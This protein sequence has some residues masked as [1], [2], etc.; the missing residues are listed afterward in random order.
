MLEIR[1]INPEEFPLVRRMN[2]VVYNGRHDFSREEAPDPLAYPHRW[3]WAAFE[4]GKMVSSLAEIPYLMR[5]DGHDARMSGIGGVG[6]LPEAR[7][8][9]N[10]RR[11]FEKL[12]GGA[13]EEGVV[14]SSLTPFSHAFYRKFGYELACSRNEV[15]ISTREFLELPMRGKFTQVFPGD[16]TADLQKIHGAYIAGLN[17]GIR[18]DFWPENRAWRMFTRDDPYTTGI[19]LYLWRDEAG[20]PGGYIQYQ[21]ITEN[22]EHLMSV[23]ELAFTCRD[24]LYGVLSL[25]SGLS[26]QFKTFLWH[27]PTFL[28]PTD[29]GPP[30]WD[31]SQRIIPRDMT[32]IINVKA[33]LELMRKP[34]GEGS[35]VLEA[36]D[37]LIPANQGKF[38]VEYGPEGVRVGPAKG[39]ADIRCDIPV[40]SQLI[41]GYRTLENALRTR[42]QGLDVFGNREILDKVFTLRPQHIT[43]YF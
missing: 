37:S 27:M 38:L 29:F 12:F 40:L 7:K 13:Y 1:R 43:E 26:A 20:K 30:L 18:R 28:D 15:R 8:G 42:Q 21:D 11:I 17:H 25:V 2:T 35:Y 41:T 19:Y 23:R 22:G 33:A 9:G 6:T 16:D 34:A 4:D 14:F 32:R 36:A 24:A 5:F 39:D 31:I 3:I 10:I